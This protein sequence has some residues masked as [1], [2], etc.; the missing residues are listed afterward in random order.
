MS[1]RDDDA[2]RANVRKPRRKYLIPLA[3]DAIAGEAWSNPLIYAGI[4]GFVGVA[5]LCCFGQASLPTWKWA[6]L[7][8]AMAAGILVAGGSLA[9]GTMLGFLFGIPR[10]IS[11]P[12]SKDTFDSKRAYQENT[13]LEQVSDWLTK[14]VIAL[15]LAQ[16]TRIPS[17]FESLSS[18][19]SRGIGMPVVTPAL[20]GI[21]LL[22]F[23]VVG[24]LIAY[25][26]T[27]LYLTH[28]FTRADRAAQE[29]PAFLE[30]LVEALLY[31]PPPDGFLQAIQRSDEYR[32]RY[33]DGNWRIWRSRACAFGQ[34]F[35]YLP[36]DR[37]NSQEGREARNEALDAVERALKLN[38]AEKEGFRRL[39]DPSLATPEESDLVVFSTDDEFKALLG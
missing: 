27:R 14:I 38:P 4:A 28:E 12:S 10:S 15:G 9:S 37:R 18:A 30:G 11:D 5:A 36:T 23:A 31:Q 3:L 19:V 39:W 22:Y 32:K 33:G 35:G 25:L 6:Q 26:W 16:L 29:T 7:V 17:A 21:I 34:R 2:N 1:E 8:S 24:F 13:N 20:T